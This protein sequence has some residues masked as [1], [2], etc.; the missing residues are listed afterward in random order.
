MYQASISLLTFA[1]LLK[2]AHSFV[3]FHSD[4]F[5]IEAY[6]VQDLPRGH[7]LCL[8]H[9]IARPLSF[10]SLGNNEMNLRTITIGLGFGFG[11]PFAQ[12]KDTSRKASH[13]SLEA[14]ATYLLG[15]S[16]SGNTTQSFLNTNTTPPL[17]SKPDSLLI[18]YDPEFSSLFAAD[19]SLDLIYVDPGGNPIAD[20]M[21]IWVWDHDQ[22]WTASADVNGTTYVSII[23]LGSNKVK[24][25]ISSNGVEVLNPNGGGYHEGKVYIAGD[26]NAT[27]PPCIYAVD[28]VTL[29]VEV[30]VDSY[31]G[32]RLN[33]PN[34]LTWAVQG[35][36]SWLFFT[37]DPLSYAYNGGP[38]P[39][40]PDATWRLDLVAKTLLPVIDRTDILVPNGIR[41]NKDGSKLYITDTPSSPLV[42]GTGQYPTSSGQ[43]AFAGS[44][45]SA[46]YVFDLDAQGF[47]YNKRLFGIAERGIAD[48]MHVDDAGRVWTAE[49]DG[50]V[51]RH[52]T[53][54]V[55]GMVNSLA[56]LESESAVLA[57]APLQNFALAGDLLVILAYDKIYTI[58]L[59]SAVVS[60]MT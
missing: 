26:G 24:R 39:Q 47:P 8:E 54:K 40:L 45:S 50:I 34:D 13:C 60:N 10:L 56:V 48:G 41:A 3:K 16:F 36:R 12:A 25:L 43:V 52:P 53:G 51:L 57:N 5:D 33:G 46:I 9:A 35:N 7:S 32:L 21:G 28:P 49:A 42:Y 38:A 1:R 17:C 14:E 2:K 59:S 20:E 11:T 31:F 55:L 6:T 30:V 29:E 27:V 23:E 18:S 58:R 15:S 4:L 19:A 22:V 37:D 44:A